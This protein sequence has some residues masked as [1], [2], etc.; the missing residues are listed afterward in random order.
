MQS[1][2]PL[3][4]ITLVISFFLGLAGCNSESDVKLDENAEFKPGVHFKIMRTT[5]SASPTLV[6][7][8]SYYCP[9]CYSFERPLDMITRVMDKDIKFSKQHVG[10]MPRNDP[11]AAN[12]MQRAHETL[13]KLDLPKDQYQQINNG[14]FSMI[15]EQGKPAGYKNIAAVFT[16]AGVDETQF[17]SIY[18]SD[19]IIDQVKALNKTIKSQRVAS[20]PD[21]IVNNKYRIDRSK[22]PNEKDLVRLINY[23]A[24]LK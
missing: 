13:V 11:K 5:A 20:V 18:G 17:K 10:F 15:Q 2:K 23:L 19:E 4:I 14:L 1:P 16:L 24:G 3:M 22:V 6:E 21:L 12:A 9:H 7:N 8:F